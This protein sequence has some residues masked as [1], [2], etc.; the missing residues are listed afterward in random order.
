M[1]HEI[2]TKDRDLLLGLQNAVEMIYENCSPGQQQYGLWKGDENLAHNMNQLR[3]QSEK[4]SNSCT[5]LGLVEMSLN[6]SLIIPR[7]ISPPCLFLV[8]KV[9][10]MKFF[11]VV[12]QYFNVTG[13][14]LFTSLSSSSPHT[15]H[16]SQHHCHIPH[17]STSTGNVV[18]SR[19]ISL[20]RALKFLRCC[21]FW[22]IRRL[23]KV[24]L[25][26]FFFEFYV[27]HSSIG[28][29][30]DAVKAIQTLPNGNKA[31]YRRGIMEV[32]S[33]LKIFHLIY[34]SGDDSDP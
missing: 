27:L 16:V 30:W 15:P 23:E 4:L 28:L 34:F 24:F 14:F 22:T 19:E 32:V 11:L 1:A 5:K 21:Q 18:T 13:I 31:A 25:R 7:L 20:Q 29:L 6:P 2:F 9:Y 10:L 3:Q 12:N 26:V 8:F 17:L 33:D